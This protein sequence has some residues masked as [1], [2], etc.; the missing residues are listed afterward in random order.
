MSSLPAGSV[1]H[2][3]QAPTC[4]FGGFRFAFLLI[5]RANIE[6]PERHPNPGWGWGWSHSWLLLK[7]SSVKINSPQLQ[8]SGRGRLLRGEWA[9]KQLSLQG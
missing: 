9:G 8:A 1:V 3:P 7:G 4:H 6:H 2:L 5:P